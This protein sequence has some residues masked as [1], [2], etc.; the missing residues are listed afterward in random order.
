MVVSMITT[1]LGLY[2]RLF[3]T[4]PNTKDKSSV[5]YACDYLVERIKL[6]LTEPIYREL[7]QKIVSLKVDELP[8]MF[9]ERYCLGK[10][11][12]HI[13]TVYP[14]N[15]AEAFI[16]SYVILNKPVP[17]DILYFKLG[18]S[19]L[20]APSL[21]N[22]VKV[23]DIEAVAAF[24]IKSLNDAEMIKT[25]ESQYVVIGKCFPLDF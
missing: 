9:I 11:S 16:L 8:P 1:I 13:L 18:A 21:I 12:D 17:L 23:L 19:G 3:I 6:D 20:L 4:N 24:L 10:L 25:T 7:L 22:G 15:V 5:K 2:E 14:V